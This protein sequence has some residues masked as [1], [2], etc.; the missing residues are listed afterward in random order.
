MLFLQDAINELVRLVFEWLK[1]TSEN[2]SPLVCLEPFADTYF[3]TKK[4]S[5]GTLN[6]ICSVVK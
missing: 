6:N 5:R 1:N 3:N 2:E 4:I